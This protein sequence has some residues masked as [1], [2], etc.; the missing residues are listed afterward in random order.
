MFNT[1]LPGTTPPVEEETEAPT[2]ADTTTEADV[3]EG[4][5]PDETVPTTD[6][7]SKPAKSGCGASLSA[8]LLPVTAAGAAL[9]VKGK[10]KE[11]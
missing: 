9:A 5:L 4:T 3:T 10:K 8:L 1:V 2:E 7:D 6:E 11:D